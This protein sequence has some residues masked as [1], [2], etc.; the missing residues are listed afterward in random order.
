MFDREL[1][2]L[3]KIKN[4]LILLVGISFLQ[5]IFIVVQAISLSKVITL[6]WSGNN[7]QS[8][9]IPLIFFSLSFLG[10]HLLDTFK[11]KELILYSRNN[12]EL[13]R[14]QFLSK[15]F[16]LGPIAIQKNGTGSIVTMALEG[17]DQV[18]NYFKLILSKSIDM[19]IIPMVILI[20]IFYFNIFCGVVLL[21]CFPLIILFM[22]IL[23]QTAKNKA[24]KQFKTYQ[25]LSN[26][27]LDSI[28]GLRSLKQLGISQKY[29]KNVY[30][31]SERFRKSTMNTLVVAM[32]S[33]FALDFFTTLSIAILAVYLGFELLN[34][35]MLL[36]PALSILILA[37]DYF[38][39]IRQFGSDYHATLNGKNSFK[40]ILQ[41]LKIDIPQEEAKVLEMWDD[42]S[43]LSINNVCV[44]YN[45]KQGLKNVSFKVEGYKKIGVV[46]L[47]GSGKSTLINTL[48]GFV[49]PNNG[50]IKVNSDILK[51][52]NQK[53]WQ[54]QLLY[55]PQNPYIFQASLYENIIFYTPTASKEDVLKAIEIVG[56]KDLVDSLPNGY[57]TMIGQ[58]AR[59]LSGGQA[60]RI[61]L[62]RVL[63]DNNRKILLFDEP[64]SHLDIE[65]ELLLKNKMIPLMENK[66]VFFATHRL[67]W[68]KEM[69]EIIV[70]RDGKVVEQGTLTQLLDKD[71]ELTR[72]I[73]EVRN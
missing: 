61:A 18:E 33:S 11:D 24:N 31:T 49:Q 7:I 66:L 43:Q 9:I 73:R 28:R 65:T 3:P 34:G 71:C 58:G 30:E 12:V 44:D 15:V 8:I 68:L 13:L 54:K 5:A 56:L 25:Q 51:N 72:L 47:S 35:H 41:L 39:P 57:D 21:L 38:L 22:I 6:L 40:N 60:Q 53:D 63:L 32:T 36:M 70:L 1:L 17:I 45:D 4:I 16:K 29:E 23:G 64:T 27:F 50:L 19:M 48:S 62:A 14:E 59:P 69:D 46:G 67:H 10:Q 26:H 42:T 52:L 37:P 2:K 20:S 55:I